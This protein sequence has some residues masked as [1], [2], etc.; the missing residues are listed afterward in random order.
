[1]SE[2]C[3]RC[4]CS[5]PRSSQAAHTQPICHSHAHGSK[6]PATHIRGTGHVIL[7]TKIS[8]GRLPKRCI[9]ALG[10]ACQPPSAGPMRSPTPQPP[11]L[12]LPV[13]PASKAA[14]TPDELELPLC[15]CR[16]SGLSTNRL[17]ADCNSGF[18]VRYRS[19]PTVQS[20]YTI[21]H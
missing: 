15:D 14:I 7:T 5:T 9:S 17:L 21:T 6:Q 8:G 12:P 11:P 19:V 3:E 20:G 10:A 4:R 2:R 13:E 18:E 16:R 1:M